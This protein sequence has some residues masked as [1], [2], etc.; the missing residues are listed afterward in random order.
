M[1]EWLVDIAF[2]ARIAHLDDADG[3]PELAPDCRRAFV[4]R[5]QLEHRAEQQSGAQRGEQPPAFLAV[6]LDR[7]PAADR[8][9]HLVR[10]EGEQVGAA[11]ASSLEADPRAL[12]L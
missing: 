5:A 2:R 10:P 9:Q 1:G 12:R 8:R 11:V 7:A 4:D 6:L 3:D